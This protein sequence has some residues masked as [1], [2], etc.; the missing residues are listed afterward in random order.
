M[1]VS[2]FNDSSQPKPAQPQSSANF[3]QNDQATSAGS[4]HFDNLLQT[5]LSAQVPTEVEALTDSGAEEA[6]SLALPP[7]A[8]E[9]AD[10]EPANQEVNSEEE[11]IL[12]NFQS[13]AANKVVPPD[14]LSDNQVTELHDETANTSDSES[15][16]NADAL[17]EQAVLLPFQRDEIRKQIQPTRQPGNQNSS[18]VAEAL[19]DVDSSQP[20]P[21]PASATANEIKNCWEPDGETTVAESQIDAPEEGLLPFNDT[22]IVESSSRVVSEASTQPNPITSIELG[23]ITNHSKTVSTPQAPSNSRSVCAR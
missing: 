9:P 15:L 4:G 13:H 1:Q 18:Q 5:G 7:A 21:V 23:G 10:A 8:V 11:P 6:D 16:A 2:T 12:L 20:E 14:Q 22:V 19:D 3:G 17:T